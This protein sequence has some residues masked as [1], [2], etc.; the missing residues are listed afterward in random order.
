M[1]FIFPTEPPLPA[2]ALSASSYSRATSE[3]CQEEGNKKPSVAASMEAPIPAWHLG[4]LRLSI[5][6]WQRS[7]HESASCNTGASD[8]TLLHFETLTLLLSFHLPLRL[9]WEFMAALVLAQAGVIFRLYKK[10]PEPLC[11]VLPRGLCWEYS[12]LVN[13]HLPAGLSWLLAELGAH[14][15]PGEL[16][17][18]GCCHKGWVGAVPPV[19]SHDFAEL[20]V[21]EPV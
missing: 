10:L 15:A 17:C 18:F 13:W 16:G 5:D 14:R 20:N 1:D 2:L 21:S 11:S 7:C 9:P 3:M 8:L 19:C 12:R 4:K 6:V